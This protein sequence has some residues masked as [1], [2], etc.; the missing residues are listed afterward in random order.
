MLTR[1]LPIISRRVAGACGTLGG[2]SSRITLQPSCS[3]SSNNHFLQ[4]NHIS[5]SQ[6]LYSSEK[7]EGGDNN[8]GG[9]DELKDKIKRWMKWNTAK[10]WRYEPNHELIA[11]IGKEGSTSPL[12]EF[13][14]LVPRSKR[15][16]ETVGRSWSVKELRRKS[17]DDLHKL[18]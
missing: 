4:R 3:T 1:A 11:Q 10:T 8:K 7:N 14:D 13:R 12:D 17:Y 5:T 16:T 9:D 18:W 6:I 2:E 15:E